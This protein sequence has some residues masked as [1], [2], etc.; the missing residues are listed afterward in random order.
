MLSDSIT[1][2]PSASVPLTSTEGRTEAEARR[3]RMPLA[4]PRLERG[5]Q[6]NFAEDFEVVVHGRIS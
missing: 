1:S 5:K 4:P 3:R 2:L 6:D